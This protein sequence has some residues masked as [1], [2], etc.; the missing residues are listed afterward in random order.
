M[1]RVVGL[2]VGLLSA[3]AV[4]V[5][6]AQP[7]RAQ[8][9]PIQQKMQHYCANWGSAGLF[10]DDQAA[11]ADNPLAKLK[12]P[13]ANGQVFEFPLL[14]I[15]KGYEL[16]D[17][18]AEWAKVWRGF[19]TACPGWPKPA[20]LVKL[21]QWRAAN[22][23]KEDPRTART[24][25]KIKSLRA[26]A[27]AKEQKA[28]ELRARIVSGPRYKA[29]TGGRDNWFAEAEQRAAYLRRVVSLDDTRYTIIG[30]LEAQSQGG[31]YIVGLSISPVDPKAPGTYT[32]ATRMFI[33]K[34]PAA[35]L[36][37]GGDF[38]TTDAK[39]LALVTPQNT[40]IVFGP[41]LPAETKAQVSK[42]RES[43][44]QTTTVLKTGKA[45]IARMLKPVEKLERE[46]KKLRA[47]ADKLEASLGR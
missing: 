36:R 3:S 4:L 5:S 44:K 46:A 27:D 15:F 30:K 6:V 41:E 26:S 18:P 47:Q 45:K 12:I 11:L 8:Q 29:I 19:Q 9:I 35:W 25:A 16:D 34:P 40:A 42:A 7:A 33:A 24:K 17:S 23:P 38:F 2:A 31:Y 1:R 32:V 21:E 39:L 10:P 14:Y 13:L 37:P 22:Q 28:S 43:L 20:W